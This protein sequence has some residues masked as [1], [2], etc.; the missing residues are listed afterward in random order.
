MA[1]LE[2]CPGCEA[3]FPQQD[4]PTHPYMLSSPACWAAFGEV[5]AREYSNPALQ[6]IHRLSVDA[7][8]VQH[9]GHPSRQSIHSVGLHLIRLCLFLEHDLAPKLADAAMRTAGRI[10]HTFI[11]LEPPPS[12]GDVTVRD[13]V[14][15]PS[16]AGHAALARRWAN[17]AWTAWAPHHP[18]IRA[19]LAQSNNSFQSMPLR[20]SA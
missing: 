10:K 3:A 19:W 1:N 16:A 17:A 14:Q 5:L 8:A 20:G 9:P 15:A 2:K 13:V 18:Q 11:W 6:P 4:G 7:Y 12:L